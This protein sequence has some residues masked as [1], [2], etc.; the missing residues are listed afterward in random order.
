MYVLLS[1]MLYIYIYDSN[2]ISHV[3]ILVNTFPSI[4]YNNA[5]VLIWSLRVTF[6]TTPN[7]TLKFVKHTARNLFTG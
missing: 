5:E 7:N 6:T 3:K 1:Y 2:T 4:I